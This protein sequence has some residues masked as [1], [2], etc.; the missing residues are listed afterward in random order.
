MSPS[1][2]LVQTSEVHPQLLSRSHR[3]E[4]TQC[5]AS[6][7]SLHCLAL[8]PFSAPPS[9]TPAACRHVLKKPSAR[10][11]LELCV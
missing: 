4:P 7:T 8:L 9:S 11:C 5:S 2:W 10:L 6:N 1:A 3:M